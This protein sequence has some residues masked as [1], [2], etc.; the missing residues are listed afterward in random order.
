MQVNYAN[1]ASQKT[2]KLIRQ[3]FAELIQEKHSIENI[4]VT[5]LAK[6]ANITRG[7]FYTH[8]E[9]IYQVAADFRE[10]IFDTFFS[11]QLTASQCSVDEFFDQVTSFLKENQ[12]TYKMLASAN[13]IPDF[14]NHLKHHLYH[15][16]AFHLTSHK[17]RRATDLRL[18][19][20][21][22]TD[23]AVSLLVKFFHNETPLNLDQINA[24]LKSRFHQMFP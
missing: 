22:F 3:T 24:Y 12:E 17:H 23:G 13:D 11:E 16:L 19:I 4:T 21:F 2:R 9:N 6:R 1:N 5:E 8:Y 14:M 18:D 20:E 7:T 15:N 10:E